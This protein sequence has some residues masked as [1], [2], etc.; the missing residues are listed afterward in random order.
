MKEIKIGCKQQLLIVCCNLINK[1]MKPERKETKTEINEGKKENK[2]EDI[3]IL[4]KKRQT[5]M[6]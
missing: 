5:K 4:E 1:G 6:C 2:M 3:L